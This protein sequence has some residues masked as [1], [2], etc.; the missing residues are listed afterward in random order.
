MSEIPNKFVW[1][2]LMASDHKAA[3]SFYRKVIGWG[4]MDAG[5]ADRSRNRFATEPILV[6]ASKEPP[7][8]WP[9]PK[10][11]SPRSEQGL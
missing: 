3:E 5:V 2:D 11:K 7:K 6:S 8:P 10:N 1:Y 9:K 4:A